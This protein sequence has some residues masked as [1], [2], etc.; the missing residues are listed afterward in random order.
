MILDT[1]KNTIM[2]TSFVLVIML[3]IEFINVKTRGSWFNGIEKRQWL[4]YIITGLMGLVPGCV[5]TFG[6]VSMYI[7]NLVSFGALIAALIATFGDEAFV[8]FALI[9]AT[10]V[11]LCIII[12]I[13]A[14]VA[15][16]VVDYFLK[17]KKIIHPIKFHFEIHQAETDIKVFDFRQMWANLRNLSFPRGALLGGVLLIIIGIIT[18]EFNEGHGSNAWD[19]EQISFFIVMVCGLF[20]IIAVSEHFLEE[21]LWNHLV[22]K[23]FLRIFLWTFGAFLFMA[24][25]QQISS[26]GCLDTI[27]PGYYFNN[28]RF[29]WHYP[30]IRPTSGFCNFI[31]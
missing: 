25:F 19:W 15:G 26:L 2:V 8:M 24:I 31:Y 6:V 17:N 13:I 11:K 27:K 9:P 12:F 23:H 7:H 29:N 22:K 4:Q 28:C 10:T 16:F 3:F 14:I 1:I 18:G 5:G 20:I 21:H 30:G